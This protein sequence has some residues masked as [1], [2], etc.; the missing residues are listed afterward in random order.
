MTVQT[1]KERNGAIVAHD[2]EGRMVGRVFTKDFKTPR[3]SWRA[4]LRQLTDNGNDLY[5]VLLNIARGVPYSAQLPDGR[6]TE[7]VV[8]SIESMRQAAK[9]LIEFLDGKA[10]PQTEVIKAEEQSS[11]LE[12]LRAMSD[13]DLLRVIEGELVKGPP[14]AYTAPILP[15]GVESVGHT[16][17]RTTSVETPPELGSS[18]HTLR[19]IFGRK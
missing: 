8:P 13:E 17:A 15:I 2:P 12:R 1:F 5:A 9:D 7:P 4:A 16:D 18:A 10:V 14:E 3:A 6:K 19:S 11:E